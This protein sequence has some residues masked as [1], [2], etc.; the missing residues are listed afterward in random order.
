VYGTAFCHRVR[1]RH[2]HKAIYEYLQQSENTWLLV[3]FLAN[4]PRLPIDIHN[5]RLSA[6]EC[7]GSLIE[8]SEFHDVEFFVSPADFAWTFIRT[9]EDF[10]LGGP[11]FVRAEWVEEA[12][13]LPS[14]R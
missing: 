8:L 4:V 1:H 5:Q 2:G 6:H 13:P 10:A 14:S 9:H 11:Y 7:V 3:P 12:T